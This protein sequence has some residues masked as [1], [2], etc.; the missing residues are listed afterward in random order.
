MS[1][2]LDGLQAFLRVYDS[3]SI[4]AVAR[5][6][7]VSQPTIS[8]RIKEVEAYYGVQLF[9][10]S[11]RTIH[12]TADATRL[13]E[14][15]R[16]IHDQ[17]ELAEASVG[18]RSA[19][20][21]GLLRITTPSFFG[22]VHIVPRLPRFY[23]ENPEVR[24]DI[25]LTDQLIDLVAAG[26]DVG[27]RVGELSSSSMVARRIGLARH[28]MI[29]SPD[30]LRRKGE[31]RIP[32]DLSRHDCVLYSGFR[33]PDRLILESEFGRRV[34]PV[35]AILHV[36]SADAMRE[37]AIAGIGLAVIPAWDVDRAVAEGRLKIVLADYPAAA[38]PINIIYPETKWLAPRTRRFI[39][40]M[41]G[42]FADPA[43]LNS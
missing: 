21:G 42:E 25:R 16:R 20:A 38:L 28:V 7:G 34:V 32:E 33:G 31:P 15:A 2:R 9:T 4:S 27:I 36:D 1:D 40:F 41:I 43:A 10:R 39:D 3:R 17:V 8:K 13:Y 14:H 29:A 23:A 26:I 12:P 22:R 37:A 30:Y 5:D 6:L 24:I 18:R 19:E 11:T 35:N